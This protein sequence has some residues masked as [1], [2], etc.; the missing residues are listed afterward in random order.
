MI[1]LIIITTKEEEIAQVSVTW[2][3]F[4]GAL[5]QFCTR[6]GWQVEYESNE[7]RSCAIFAE[8]WSVPQVTEFNTEE[9]KRGVTNDIP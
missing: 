7:D 1:A 8:S 3:E 6:Q 4:L 9:R 5:E 2:A